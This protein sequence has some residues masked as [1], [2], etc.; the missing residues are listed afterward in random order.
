VTP[1]SQFEYE[2]MVARTRRGKF[3]AK[4]PPT[5]ADDGPEADLHQAILDECARR[6]F[7]VFHG[8]MAHK[9][10][11]SPGEPDFHVFGSKGRF[12]MIECKTRTAKL[13]PDQL[14][15]K[16]LAEINGHTVHVVRSFEQFL[17]LIDP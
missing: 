12:W 8:S 5:E 13:S 11:R 16:L 10:M 15:V 14:G 4:V 17:T 1:I 7:L 9:A 3:N 6:R 2:Q